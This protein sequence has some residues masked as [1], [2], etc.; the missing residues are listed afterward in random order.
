MHLINLETGEVVIEFKKDG[1]IFYNTLL[2]K[3]MKQMGI[4]IPH[5]LRGSYHG[6]DLIHLGDPDFER[7]FREIYYLTY[8]SH[9]QFAWKSS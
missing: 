4:A 3:E 5:G 2:E 7:A 8:L 9:K 1:A 6:K